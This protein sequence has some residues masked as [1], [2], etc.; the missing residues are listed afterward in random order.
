M[1]DK[2][3]LA[4]LSQI[5]ELPQ[6][7]KSVYYPRSAVIVPLVKAEG[8]LSVL[9]EVR[10]A[11]LSWQPGDICFP[12]GRIEAQDLNPMAAAVRETS[13]ELGIASQNIKVLSTLD[14][15]ASN[16]G[17]R[18]YPFVGYI[19]VVKDLKPNPQEVA[20]IFTVPVSFLLAT[21]P[22]TGDMEMATKP[23]P[24]FPFELLPPDYPREWK[25]RTAYTV[26]FYKYKQ[27][28]IWGLTAKVLSNFLESYRTQ[29]TAFKI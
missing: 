18:V 5:F 28:V 2:E 12:G 9:F 17:V 13:E 6:K 15:V 20:E 3:I 10:S 19:S 11:E 21:E 7:I 24:E 4:R 23:K 25:I 14:D 26:S 29:L 27:H 16:I 22:V 1:E 8:V